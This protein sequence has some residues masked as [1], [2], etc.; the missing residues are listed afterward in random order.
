MAVRG[1]DHHHVCF[2]IDQGLG[3]GET[4]RAHAGR[5]RNPKP[6]LVVLGRVRVQFRLF[7]VLDG[8][9]PNTAVG[10]VDHQQFFDPIFVQQPA[11]FRHVYTFFHRDKVFLCHKFADRLVGLVGKP[12]ISVGEYPD[13]L[14]A[15]SFYHRNARN[16]LVFHQPQSVGQSLLRRD[17]D[18]VDHHSGLKLL[19]C[20]HFVGLVCHIHVFVKHADATSL[21]HR[22][23]HF[24][25]R[26]RVHRRR[27]QRD[28]KAD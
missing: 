8:D 22:N 17:R 13:Q 19:D 5:R 12:D 24:R 6:A 20:P 11:R 10:I 4:V 18:R 23:C 16:P 26:D 9:Q 28:T 25:F 7:N 14:A 2:R 21:R 27:D 15:V 1:V 3:A